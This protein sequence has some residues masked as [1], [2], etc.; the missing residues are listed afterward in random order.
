MHT[1]SCVHKHPCGYFYVGRT[2]KKQ[3]KERFYEHK[4]AMRVN[5]EDCPMAKLYKEIQHSDPSYL[6]IAAKMFV[7]YHASVSSLAA[8]FCSS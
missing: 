8:I 3:L 2:K 1:H 7:C 4:Y 6:R 5:N